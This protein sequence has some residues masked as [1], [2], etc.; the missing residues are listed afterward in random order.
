MTAA[1]TTTYVGKSPK[2]RGVSCVLYLDQKDGKSGVINF[3]NFAFC[4]KHEHP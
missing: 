2:A 1:G 4:G 3:A